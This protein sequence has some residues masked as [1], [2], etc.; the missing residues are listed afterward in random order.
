MTPI[1]S[2]SVD[3][4]HPPTTSLAE[5]VARLAP[6][7]GSH[8]TPWDGLLCHHSAGPTA[9]RPVVYTPSLCVVAQGAKQGL[10]GDRLYRYDPLHY[11]VI[12]APM[13]LR[14]E[15]VDASP[16]RPFLSCSL[17]L[18][19][20]VIHEL[21]VEIEAHRH[22]EPRGTSPAEMAWD[23]DGPPLRISRLDGTVADALERFLAALLEPVDRQVLAPAAYRELIYLLLG[24][25]QGD[26][27]RLAAQRAGG[28]RARGVARALRYLHENL[29]NSLDVPTVARAAGMSPSSLHHAFKDATTYSP[30]QYLK[31]IRLHEARRLMLDSG[32]QAAEAALDVGYAS[33]SQFSREFKRLFGEPPGRYVRRWSGG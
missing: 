26:L 4:D 2:P 29:G 11:L 9:P 16:E 3:R 30:I 19:V 18:D 25:E 13:P 28:Q 15:I 6:R 21:L 1:A 33:P 14:A 17:S 20:A 23:A 27:I 7:P 22:D 32:R 5:L 24:R 31:Q 8:S 12:G 10:L